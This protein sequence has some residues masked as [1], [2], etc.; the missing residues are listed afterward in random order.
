ML[1]KISFFSKMHS[2]SANEE[3]AAKEIVTPDFALAKCFFPFPHFM[4]SLPGMELVGWLGL[5]VMT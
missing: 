4:V 5:V 3:E 2:A 1:K